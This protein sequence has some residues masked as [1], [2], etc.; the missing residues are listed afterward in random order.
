VKKEPP[1]P[2]IAPGSV[3]L[4]VTPWGEIYVNGKQRGLSPPIKSL[5]LAPGKYKIEIRNSNLAPYADTIEIKSREELT[6]RH[7][8]N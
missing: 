6:I 4:F 1:P 8:F 5:K 2:Q 7:T 3:N